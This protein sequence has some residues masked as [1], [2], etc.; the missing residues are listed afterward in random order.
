MIDP[1]AQ[2]TV[3]ELTVGV[4]GRMGRGGHRGKNWD[5]CNTIT[6]KNDLKNDM[7]MNFISKEISS[8]AKYSVNS[9]GLWTAG[10][11]NTQRG[12]SQGNVDLS[13]LL[14]SEFQKGL[15]T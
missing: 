10:T 14:L 3:W 7:L 13:S 12:K 4:G 1:W 15:V 2:T 5:N 6:I 8:L 9:G 11:Q